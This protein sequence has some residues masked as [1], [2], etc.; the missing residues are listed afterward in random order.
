MSD[1][2]QFEIKF[3]GRFADGQ[4]LPVAT[5]TQVLGAMQRAVHLLAMQHQNISVRQRERIN[6]TV[7]T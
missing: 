1:K 3:E 5:L 7:D 2:R 4:I 6:K